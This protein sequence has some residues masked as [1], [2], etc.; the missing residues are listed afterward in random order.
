[1][2]KTDKDIETFYAKTAQEW[3]QWLQENH[4]SKSGVWLVTYKKASGVATLSWS[5][6]VDEALCFGW[7]DSIKKKLDEHAS[8]QYFGPRKPK[9]IWSKINK[10]KIQ[11]LTEEGLMTPAGQKCVDIARQ[12]GSW[13]IY[14]E[15]EEQLIP[16]DLEKAFKKHKGSKDYFEGLGKSVRKQML[17]W[18][19]SAKR[20]ETREK[21]I[22]E[23]AEHA[24]RKVKPK[25]F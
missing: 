2:Q 11:R 4:A 9:S 15:V 5:D 3:R 22:H 20:P 21:R 10:A 12:N 17:Y 24:G 19:V 25:Q 6:S 1:M 8:I 7:I 18:V 13:H 16:P 14:D 23:I